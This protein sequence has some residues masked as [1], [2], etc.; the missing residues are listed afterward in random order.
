MGDAGLPVPLGLL[1][2]L[3]GLLQI[4]AGQGRVHSAVHRF[5]GVGEYW[6]V[7]VPSMVW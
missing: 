3:I 5:V 1:P 7:P 4:G 6:A 2:Q